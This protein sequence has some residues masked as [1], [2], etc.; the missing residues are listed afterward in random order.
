MQKWQIILAPTLSRCGLNR[1]HLVVRNALKKQFEGLE[2]TGEKVDA[3]VLGNIAAT[4][5]HELLQRIFAMGMP[6]TD[7]VALHKGRS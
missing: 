6:G 5:N 2:A 4:W 7:L 3:L 1:C